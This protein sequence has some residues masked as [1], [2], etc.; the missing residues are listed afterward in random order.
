LRAGTYSMDCTLAFTGTAGNPIIFR[1]YPGERVIIAGSFALNG[2]YTH[3]Y[4]LEFTGRSITDR[5]STE[6]GSPQPSDISPYV[7]GV[8]VSGEGNKLINCII[9]DCNTNGISSMSDTTTEIY[10]CLVYYNGWEAPDRGH[11]HAIYLQSNTKTKLIKD[12]VV[13]SNFGLGFHAYTEGGYIN[14]IQAVGVTGYNN[15]CLSSVDPANHNV[16]QYGGNTAINPVIDRCMSYGASGI[17]LNNTDYATLTNNYSSDGIENANYTNL[18]ES[19]NTAGTVGNVVFVRDNTYKS[20][21]AN[22][23]IYNEA[24]A[25]TVS[26][27]LTSVTGLDVGD[28]VRV[29]NTRDYFTDIQT[30]TLDGDQKITVNM[31]AVNRTIATPAGWTAPANT[32]PAFGCFIVEKV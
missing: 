20:G 11:G 15:G 10:G 17:Y 23:T 25:N 27:D 7:G 26:V 13:H 2:S 1:A 5:L 16:Y 4:D 24:A 28:Q 19:G 3:V 32:F 14:N 12:C 30:L 22:V 18:T 8:G 21:R 29:R 9:H 6:T 31:Q